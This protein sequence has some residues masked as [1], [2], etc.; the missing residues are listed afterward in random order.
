M[1]Y[2]HLSILS[3]FFPIVPAWHLQ[4]QSAKGFAMK[5]AIPVWNGCVSSAFDFSHSLLL[6]EFEDGREVK[7]SE[8]SSS[9]QSIPEKA[10]QLKSLGV[11]VLI[12]G[13]ISR[14]LASLVSTSG[15]KV[16]PYVVGQVDEILEAYLTDRL[17]QPQFTLP[18]SWPGA[19][20]GFRR[21]CR[22]RRARR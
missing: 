9:A 16:L 15:I 10:N 19:R 22:A 5:I 14:S 18:G 2:R 3:A 21:R 11:E 7:R 6:V 8:V 12:C 17:V 4:K 1:L 13:A 20:R